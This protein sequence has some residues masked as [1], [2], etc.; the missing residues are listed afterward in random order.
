MDY[1]SIRIS[2]LSLIWLEGPKKGGVTVDEAKT[3][4]DWAQEYGLPHSEGIEIHSRRRF[5]I[6]HIRIGP[7][8]HIPVKMMK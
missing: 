2:R 3:L 4:L 7:E 6:P 8:N 1:A 5:N